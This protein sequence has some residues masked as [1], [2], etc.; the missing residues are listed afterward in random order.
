MKRLS[1]SVGILV[2]CHVHAQKVS[3]QKNIDSNTQDFLSGLA[4]TIDGQYLVSGS[5]IQKD[6]NPSSNQNKGYDYHILKLD[7]QG[8]CSKLSDEYSFQC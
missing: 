3:W 1:I 4:V 2:L 8:S 5:S 6:Q 7:Q